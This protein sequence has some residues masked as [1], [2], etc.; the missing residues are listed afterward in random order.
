M[1]DRVVVRGALNDM[2]RFLFVRCTKIRAGRWLMGQ[3][4]LL[5][6]RGARACRRNLPTL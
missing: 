4:A 5:R 3:V 6:A 1:A 2:G